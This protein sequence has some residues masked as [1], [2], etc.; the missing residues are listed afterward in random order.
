MVCLHVHCQSNVFD[1]LTCNECSMLIVDT[2]VASL[3]RGEVHFKNICALRNHLTGVLNCSVIGNVCIIGYLDLFHTFHSGF[4][5]CDGGTLNRH[6]VL[7]S[8]HGRVDGDLVISLVTVRQTQ[9]IILQLNINIV[10]DELKKN[11]NTTKT[12]KIQISIY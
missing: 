5:G 6:V 3:R 1:H 8:S 11:N 9:V 7:L 12:H 4:V 2:A 10:Q